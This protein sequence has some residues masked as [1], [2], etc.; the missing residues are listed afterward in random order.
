MKNLKYLLL[1]FAFIFNTSCFNDDLDD[2]IASSRDI[3]D[4]IWKGMNLWYFWQQEES[5]PDLAD[6]R[7]TTNEEYTTYL[8]GFDSPEAL[9]ESL[10]FNEDRFSIITSNYNDL[11]NSLNGVS[12]SNGMEFGLARIDG[13]S[14]LLGFVQYVVPNSNA[15]SQNVE[16]GMLFRTV[17]GTN[18][19]ENNFGSLLFGENTSY[20]IGLADIVNDE[21][22]VNGNEITLLKQ[23]LTENPILINEVYEIEGIKIGY[24]MYNSFNDE[25]DNQLNAVF[26]EF[27]SENIDE[28]ILDLRYN[29]GGSVGTT[30]RL[31]SM[32]TGQYTGDVFLRSVYNDKLNEVLSEEDRERNFVNELADG[33]AI[34]S[35]NLNSLYVLAQGSSASASELLINSL[36]ASPYLGNNLVHIGDVTVGKNEFSTVLLDAPDCAFV[37]TENCSGP[38]NPNHT[39][40]MLP[41]LGRNANADGFFE[42]TDGLNP[43]ITFEEDISNLGVLGDVTEPLLERAIQEIIGTR[44]SV[45]NTINTN[46]KT[47]TSSK[48]F[49]PIKDNMV[50]DIDTS[51][52][53]N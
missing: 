20:T 16:R 45:N 43:D 49:T 34:N 47:I 7:F 11:I 4:F 21:I 33:S 38:I 27:A 32:I 30:I 50:M 31:S 18:L 2:N 52:L 14:E 41:L 37:L 19:N 5:L 9:F 12:L 3:N 42:F 25:F 6:D 44:A 35:L 1:S 39:Y 13:G 48:F 15:A 24:L 8:D 26:A 36:S 22:V 28:L 29:L 40:G 53:N 17:D 10:L 23:T 51:I 46:F